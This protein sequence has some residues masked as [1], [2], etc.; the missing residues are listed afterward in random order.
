VQQH[1]KHQGNKVGINQ[2]SI[3]RKGKAREVLIVCDLADHSDCND[4][5]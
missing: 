4:Y 5:S 2:L 3:W 1:A